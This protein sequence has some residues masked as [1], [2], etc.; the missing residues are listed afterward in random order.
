V[1]VRHANTK[2]RYFISGLSHLRGKPESNRWLEA[3]RAIFNNDMLKMDAPWCKIDHLS[4]EV[5][6]FSCA[7]RPS[8]HMSGHVS[9]SGFDPYMKWLGI[10]PEEQP[11]NHYRLLGVPPYTDDPDVIDN[12]A[13]QRM[14]YLRT[15]HIGSRAS[16]AA[17]LLN[18]ISAARVCLLNPAAKSRYDDLLNGGTEAEDE[19][20][21]AP[22]LADA[23]PAD[24][25]P[26]A[27]LVMQ[28]QPI[29]RSRIRSPRKSRGEFPFAAKVIGGGIVGI[30]I[31][32]AIIDVLKP[33]HS[34]FEALKGKADETAQEP[35]ESDSSGPKPSSTK[36]STTTPARRR[37]VSRPRADATPSDTDSPP[38]SIVSNEDQIARLLAERDGLIAS[39]DLQA[40]LGV[41]QRICE[42]D[43]SN[44]VESK[45]AHIELCKLE[46][47]FSQ[48]VIVGEQINVVEEA[49]SAG[50]VDLAQLCIDNVLSSA[51]DLDDDEFVRRATLAAIKVA[52]TAKK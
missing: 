49:L 43:G 36:T 12:A 26:E 27:A 41:V 23:A 50:R 3:D 52:E 25:K 13:D 22:P 38:P 2:T 29:F 17:Q 1:P 40:S 8:P 37:N 30:V 4:L 11:P 31:A 45:L 33:D 6:C 21:A 28:P 20:V 44:V 48:R 39:G 46:D 32:L 5:V 51:R 35:K 18:E 10:P 15:L 34:L 19:E 47:G 7:P 14:S 42:I 16:L 24:R 9:H